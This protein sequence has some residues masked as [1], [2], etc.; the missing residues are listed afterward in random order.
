M[1]TTAERRVSHS[2]IADLPT[3]CADCAE[4]N[5][6]RAFCGTC[7]VRHGLPACWRC[8]DKRWTARDGRWTRCD[9][10]RAAG[11]ETRGVAG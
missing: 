5:Q 7:R 11:R 10:D 2:R 6:V 9:A 8:G 1:S 4:L 3:D